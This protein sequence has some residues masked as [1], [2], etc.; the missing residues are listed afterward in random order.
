MVW[1]RCEVGE[2]TIDV[3]VL[4]HDQSVL[5]GADVPDGAVW[6]RARHFAAGLMFELHARNGAD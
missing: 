1:K 5:A 2:D 3:L 6:I 4:R